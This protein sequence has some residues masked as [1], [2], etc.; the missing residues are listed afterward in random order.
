MGTQSSIPVIALKREKKF[1]LTDGIGELFVPHMFNRFHLHHHQSIADAV[2]VNLEGVFVVR[3][4]DI[5]E[6]PKSE[7]MERLASLLK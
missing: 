1:P 2:I 7:N 4:T 3:H 6:L 5:E